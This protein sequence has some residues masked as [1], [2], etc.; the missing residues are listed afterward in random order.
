MPTY[1]Y[2][3]EPCNVETEEFHGIRDPQ[4][5]CGKC[6][7]EQKRLIGGAPMVRKGAGLWSYDVASKDDYMRDEDD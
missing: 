5:P 2:L 7:G 1:T 6:G 3:C 4:P